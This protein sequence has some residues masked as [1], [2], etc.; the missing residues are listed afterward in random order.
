MKVNSGIISINEDVLQ[1]L[2]QVKYFFTRDWLVEYCYKFINN[3]KQRH[4]II[5]GGPGT[6][7]SVFIADLA[8]RWNC[9]RHFIRVGHTR[10]ITG[11][12][13]KAFLISI[14]TQLYQRY[15]R[16]IFEVSE[17]GK[18]RVNVGKTEDNAQ[19][20]G[21][22]IKE[23]VRLP[24]LPVSTSEVNVDVKHTS[25]SAR[26]YGEFIGKWIDSSESLDPETLLHVAVLNPLKRLSELEQDETVVILIDAL[27]EGNDAKQTDIY[28]VL[29]SPDD[30]DYPVNLKCIFT[31][32]QK[33]QARY[34]KDDC[35]F[36]DRYRNQITAELSN[37]IN[38]ALD[39]ELL[40]PCL[41]NWTPEERANYHDQLL[42]SS[43]YNLLFLYHYI[44]ELET[45]ILSG[46]LK[47]L[48]AIR[49]PS[50]IDEIY[51]YFAVEKIKANREM[52]EWIGYYLPVLGL[53]AVVQGYVTRK[54]LAAF[55]GIEQSYV[56]YVIPLLAPFLETDDQGQGYRFFHKSFSDYLLDENRNVDYYLEASHYHRMIATYYKQGKPCW[57]DVIWHK[58]PDDYPYKNLATHLELTGNL[59]D[60]YDLI[61]QAWLKAQ[62]SHSGSYNDFIEDLLLTVR[63]AASGA[64][65]NIY[66]LFRCGFIHSRIIAICSSVSAETIAAMAL[67]GQ[68]AAAEGYAMLVKNSQKRTDTYFL[69]ARCN[70]YLVDA[71]RALS[72]I[73]EASVAANSIEYDDLKYQRQCDIA[74]FLK[75]LGHEDEL[76]KLGEHVPISSESMTPQ[77]LAGRGM[78]NARFWAIKL[79]NL[80]GFT[81]RNK[82]LVDEI[83]SDLKRTYT[84]LNQ[85]IQAL[86]V[87]HSSSSLIQASKLLNSS[88]S[89]RLKLN[90]LSALA[91]AYA[92]QEVPAKAEK[93]IDS[94]N[95]IFASPEIQRDTG[96]GNYFC[97]SD[98][99]TIARMA[100]ACAMVGNSEQAFKYYKLVLEGHHFNRDSY[101]RKLTCT[102]AT[103]FYK[104][105]HLIDKLVGLHASF[106]N[107]NHND[108]MGFIL[109]LYFNKNNLYANEIWR[110][111]VKDETSD[112]QSDS[113][114]Y[115]LA[116]AFYDSSQAEKQ[117]KKHLQGLSDISLLSHNL[118]EIIKEQRDHV[119]QL[120]ELHME[121][122]GTGNDVDYS[123]TA[124]SPLEFA[125]KYK[126]GE[127]NSNLIYFSE[128]IYQFKV[129]GISTEKATDLANMIFDQDMY[130]LAS[131]EIIRH[132][133]RENDEEILGEFQKLIKLAA[134][135][136]L[137]CIKQLLY[138]EEN[139]F[140]TDILSRLK[141]DFNDINQWQLY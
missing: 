39:D 72:L 61:G 11:S 97:D 110:R 118:D 95:E 19:V 90:I 44:N 98:S 84:G 119:Y 17:K 85:N 78:A 66:Q 21:R 18:V 115:I 126:G 31:T 71:D 23:I 108:W 120:V 100:R 27:D 37:Y 127:E 131:L 128:I 82:Q 26:T 132:M 7:K 103:I 15:G 121:Y 91:L 58:V 5:V 89:D 50:G 32:R 1:R 92:Y 53:L 73:H 56:D 104:N 62:F 12:S 94:F 86:S 109:E 43:D 2:S 69:L 68:M 136:G 106:D 33:N 79:M 112:K 25:G 8:N 133:N 57:Q 80:T 81:E 3:S 76:K 129:N 22:Y 70:A 9:P 42:Q 114:Y 28:S 141:A 24:F 64:P 36:L 38:Y 138:F 96:A 48:R 45:Q 102:L 75:Q 130:V 77:P 16:D 123:F 83:S 47:D 101:Q 51:R 49:I 30:A 20:F 111:V 99:G 116:L 59:E 87:A 65:P 139:P 134:L 93:C 34:P 113:G 55:S 60:L 67:T 122:A 74:L 137:T 29:P 54:Q 117:L 6:G 88:E 125:N 35:L 135:S 140:D 52:K 4:L 41:A 124:E 107:V 10:G 40:Q 14:G 46:D 105:N 63:S 13:T